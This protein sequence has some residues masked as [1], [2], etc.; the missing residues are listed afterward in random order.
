MIEEVCR[1]WEM[2]VLLVD[3]A[4]VEVVLWVAAT[5]PFVCAQYY[6]TTFLPI[7][8]SYLDKNYESTRDNWPSCPV[9]WA[10]HGHYNREIFQI[11]RIYGRNDDDNRDGGHESRGGKN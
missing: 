3:V 1:Y 5:R 6:S 7:I 4:V 11:F 10:R 2:V 9:Y 8:G